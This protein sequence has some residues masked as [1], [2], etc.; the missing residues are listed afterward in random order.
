[1]AIFV[2]IT[3]IAWKPDSGDFEISTSILSKHFSRPTENINSD[4]IRPTTEP[5]YV[6]NNMTLSAINI[7]ILIT[8]QM[9]SLTKTLLSVLSPFVSN[10]TIYLTRIFVCRPSKD[11]T[12][13]V[14]VK[15]RMFRMC[16]NI[17]GGTLYS[18][19]KHC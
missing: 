5:I 18:L 1:M 14:T 3:E 8:L 11:F 10:F 15:E 16:V 17:N 9:Q 12:L 6:I 7:S 13:S 19:F 4:P 2:L